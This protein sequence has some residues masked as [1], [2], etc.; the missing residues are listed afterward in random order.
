MKTF[1]EFINEAI[2]VKGHDNYK[3]AHGKKP[4]GHGNWHIGIGI[5]TIDH[6]RHKEGEHYISHNGKLSDAVAKAKHVAKA[7][8]INSV[9][10]QS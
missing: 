7:Q 3:F 2:E 10:I 5:S 6:K 8:G 9:H 4:S 1:E